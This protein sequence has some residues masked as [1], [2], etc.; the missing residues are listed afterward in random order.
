MLSQCSTSPDNPGRAHL[1]NIIF[2]SLIEWACLESTTQS[3][4]WPF[5]GNEHLVNYITVPTVINLWYQYPCFS[6]TADYGDLAS[7]DSC[8]YCNSLVG[9]GSI[10]GIGD[11]DCIQSE[12]DINSEVGSKDNPELDACI[13]SL[14]GL[15][16]TSI[17]FLL[18]KFECDKK[19]GHICMEMSMILLQFTRRS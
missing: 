16:Y 3:Y 4:S 5:L 7:S 6:R 13:P 17:N 11:D 14:L 9:P 12:A 1:V 2:F 15:R 10:S 8:G 19:V 18:V